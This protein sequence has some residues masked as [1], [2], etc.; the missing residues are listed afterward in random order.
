MLVCN[1]AS[2]PHG[3]SVSSCAQT[4]I[5]H[6]PCRFF[7]SDGHR[8]FLGG[9]AKLNGSEAYREGQAISVDDVVVGR[10][11]L[12]RDKTWD[13]P[14]EINS[15][16]M[17]FAH[18]STCLNLIF[19]G[20]NHGDVKKCHPQRLGPL[21][22]RTPHPAGSNAQAPSWNTCHSKSPN[23]WGFAGKPVFT[24]L[25]LD[26]TLKYNQLTQLVPLTGWSLVFPFVLA[27]TPGCREELTVEATALRYLNC[28]QM[29]WQRFEDIFNT[30]W[31]KYRIRN[32][33]QQKHELKHVVAH[34]GSLFFIVFPYLLHH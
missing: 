8:R 25:L 5:N 15:S 9:A 3:S 29:W 26:E 10:K 28:F 12:P 20:K 16:F 24:I 14:S 22:L 18:V 4:M 13:H 32:H 17:V 30:M 21:G 27:P 31:K 7:H 34:G 1:F 33:T 2:C 11:A 23:D 6:N 19:V